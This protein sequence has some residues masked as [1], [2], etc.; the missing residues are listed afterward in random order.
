VADLSD[1]TDI[2]PGPQPRPAGPIERAAPRL[3]KP[4]Q[5]IKPRNEKRAKKRH[6]ECYAEQADACRKRPCLVPKCWKR[7][8]VPH[9]AVSRGA[10]GKD[11]QCVPLC[12]EHHSW[13]HD[14]P[15]SEFLERFGV[16]LEAEASKL[17][18]ELERRRGHD[19]EQHAVLRENAATL[20]SE[21]VCTRCGYVLPDEQ[22]DDE[23]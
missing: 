21:Y 11:D 14:K 6:D 15:A 1:L 7:P 10:G 12:W 18:A 13:A 2:F 22:E 17:A 23:A 8:C 20:R 9:H 5:P 16:D 4:P 19:C 3:K